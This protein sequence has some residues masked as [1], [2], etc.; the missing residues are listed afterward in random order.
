M[1]W[2]SSRTSPNQ[3]AAQ[4]FIQEVLSK[5][6]QAKLLSF[7]FL[8]LDQA[9]GE[10]RHQAARQEEAAKHAVSGR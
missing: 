2:R 4:A 1:R 10:D 8:P 7:G 9:E 5:A 3:A 6:G